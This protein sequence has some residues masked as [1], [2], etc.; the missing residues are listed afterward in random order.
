MFVKDR[1]EFLRKLIHFGG[2]RGP[3][4]SF[5]IALPLHTM[6][7]MSIS[8]VL[9][10]R[11]RERCAFPAAPSSS[12]YFLH[13]PSHRHPFLH[14]RKRKEFFASNWPKKKLGTSENLL[15][16]F[17]NF[18]PFLWAYIR[19]L[20]IFMICPRKFP[21]FPETFWNCLHKIKWMLLAVG[22]N[23]FAKKHCCRPGSGCCWQVKDSLKD[24]AQKVVA[25]SFDLL[26][27]G[28]I[29]MLSLMTMMFVLMML[30]TL[31]TLMK[32]L[33]LMM[34]IRLLIPMLSVKKRA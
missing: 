32:F 6:L 16:K 22:K 20:W 26:P 18:N 1:L 14:I 12:F 5:N 23:S 31:T 2:G 13:F 15:W 24:K 27:S 33:T 4:D 11:K 19:F 30:M 29:Q 7:T 3:L 21:N 10:L 8:W 25:S 9:V 28:M 17:T 34:L